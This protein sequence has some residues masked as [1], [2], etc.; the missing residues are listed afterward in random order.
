MTNIEEW[1]IAGYKGCTVSYR[2][3]QYTLLEDPHY[4]IKPYQRAVPEDMPI[5]VEPRA[6]AT[7]ADGEVYEVYWWLSD[8]HDDFDVAAVAG[9]IYWEED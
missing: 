3:E 7:G 4:E 9:V 8:E 6:R 2:G 1:V 5:T